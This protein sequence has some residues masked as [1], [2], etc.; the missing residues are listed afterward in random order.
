MGT[1]DTVDKH[2]G[3][4]SHPVEAGREY[5]NLKPQQNKH[6]DDRL[7]IVQRNTVTQICAQ[8]AAAI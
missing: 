6:R 8:M 5:Q 2:S 7:A 3:K 1:M 4:H